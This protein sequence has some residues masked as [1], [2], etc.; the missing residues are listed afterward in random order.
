MF[1]VENEHNILIYQVQKCK[2]SDGLIQELCFNHPVKFISSINNISTNNVQEINVEHKL[3]IQNQFISNDTTSVTLNL[4][5]NSYG[6]FKLGSN[7]T[8]L[9]LKNLNTFG[10]QIIIRV[11][12]Q[13]LIL[14][15]NITFNKTTTTHLILLSLPMTLICCSFMSQTN[16][17]YF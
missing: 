14:P 4:K 5:S 8:R 1:M 16:I 9:N 17:M 3:N 7:L 11:Q 15:E 13:S 2:P 12:E 6:T 10:T